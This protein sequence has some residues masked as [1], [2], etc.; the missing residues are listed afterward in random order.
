MRYWPVLSVTALRL[1]SISAGLDASTVTP[2]STAPE[3]SFTTPVMEAWANARAGTSTRSRNAPNTT[4]DLR[5]QLSP[6]DQHAAGPELSGLQRVARKLHARCGEGSTL[7][8]QLAGVY[9]LPHS[10]KWMVFPSRR[11]ASTLMSEP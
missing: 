6:F 9:T 2:G 11:S 3:A 10:S 8:L 1:F 4:C 5:M 7:I